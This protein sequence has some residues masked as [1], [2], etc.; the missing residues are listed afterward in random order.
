MTFPAN[1]P[2]SPPTVRFTSEMWHPNVYP[3]GRVCI[4]ILHPPGDDPNGY[5]LASERW[6]PV[7]TGAGS[8]SR[9]IYIDGAFD[10]FHAGHVEI[11]PVVQALGDFS[12]VGIYSD[13]TVSSVQGAYRPIINLHERSLSVLACRYEQPNPYRVPMDMGILKQLESPLNITTS[14][15]IRRVVANHEA[16]QFSCPLLVEDNLL[17]YSRAYAL[18]RAEKKTE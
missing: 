14:T 10:L 3:D 17:Y 7:H 13:Q 11:L 18:V 5:E 16:Y 9:I 12:I 6:T 4:S 1:Y 8:E 15:I 2:N